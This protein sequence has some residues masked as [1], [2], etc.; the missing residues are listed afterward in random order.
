MKK[1]LAIKGGE[2]VRSNFFPGHYIIGKEEKDAIIDFIDSKEDLSGFLGGWNDKF[3]GGRNVRKFEDNWS[4]YINCK[5]T[6]SFNSNT[7]GLVSAI[8]AAGIEPGDEVIVTPYT[9]SATATAILAYQGIPIFADIDE[10]SFC[11]DPIEVEKKIS[12]RTK[13]IMTTGI[14]GHPSQMDDLIKIAKKNNLVVI[15]DAAQAPGAI[16]KNIKIGS[17]ADMTV[18]SLNVH[19]HIHTGEGGMVTTNNDDFAERLR[20]IRNHGEAVLENKKQEDI[21]NCFG[22]NLRLTE[23]QAVMAIEQLKKLPSLL[24]QRIENANFLSENLSQIPGIEKAYVQKDCKHVYYVQPFKIKS[25]DLE[26]GRNTFI[27]AVSK[28][29]PT[30][31]DRKHG[32]L[33]STG[34]CTPLYLLPLFQKK[35][36]FG[37]NHW[38][39]SY[40]DQSMS[41]DYSQGICPKTEYI[42]KNE[43]F[44]NDFIR[45]PATLNDMQDV[46]N[47]FEKVYE[48]KKEIS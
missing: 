43:I 30:A 15:E 33:I 45:P 16:Y 3:L 10:R 35:I 13:A 37:K 1:K 24:E 14:F 7:S 32:H 36:A 9:M 21:S 34:F 23:I 11:L 40:D 31:D 26:V 47:A 27:E 17:K 22:F 41:V 38:P 20:L 46:V 25:D 42:E 5:Y 28:E 4:E 48:N 39:F 6:I 29:L 2:P 8:G 18:F 19:K 12:S 44:I